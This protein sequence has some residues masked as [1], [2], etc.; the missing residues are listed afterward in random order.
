[1]SN[2]EKAPQ[3]YRD[4][5]EQQ[6]LQLEEK[7]KKLSPA[8]AAQFQRESREPRATVPP[9]GKA[10][11]FRPVAA[12]PAQRRK[13]VKSRNFKGEAVL[14]QI[15][16]VAAA[17]SEAE[18][19]IYGVIGDDWLDEG[20][21]A[22]GFNNALKDIG[23]VKNIKLRINSG[24]GDVF[25]AT[26]IYNMLVKHPANVVIE[27]EGVAASA[28]TIIAMAG[29]EIRIAANAHWM[30]H[31]ASGGVWGNADEMR[32]YI[33]LLDNADEMIRLTYSARTGIEDGELV[34]MMSTNNWMTAA[35]AL[36]LGFVDSVDEAKK[37]EAV[38]EPDAEDKEPTPKAI[39][40]ERLA[41]IAD[42][43]QNLSLT[44]EPMRVAASANSVKLPT[45]VD[46]P[47]ET[48]EGNEENEM[49]KELRA[50]LVAAGMGSKLSDKEAWAWLDAN[51]EKVYGASKPAP[52]PAPVDKTPVDKT[53]VPVAI[54]TTTVTTSQP[55]AAVTV[56][57]I[58]AVI[59]AREQRA[60]AKRKEW[61][62][63]VDAHVSLVFDDNVPAGLTET[64]YGLQADG[65]GPVRE[66]L[67]KAKKA[68]ADEDGSTLGTGVNL[69][70][71]QP[72]D[73]HLQAIRAGLLVRS[74]QNFVS[75]SPR[76]VKDEAGRWNHV[77]RSPQEVME[78]HLP[79]KD[80]PKD[81]QAFAS[82]PLVKLAEETLLADGHSH[83]SI[84]R[85]NG[86]S[87]AMAA[88]GYAR[89][90]GLKNIAVHTT[91]SFPEITRDA[92]NK[93]LQVG[94]EEAPQTW[95]GPMRQGTS[96]SD[97]KD[98]HRVKLGAAANL[99]VWPDN[100]TPEVAKLSEEKEKYA[101]EAHAETLQFSWRLI[102]NDDLDALSR[103]P[104]LLGDAA[105]RTVNAVAWAEVTGNPLL[106]DGVALFA[107]AAGARKRDNLI[108]GSATPTN[109]TIGAQKKLM[110]LMR[111]LNTP[112]GNESEDI[113]NLTPTYI[114][115]PAALEEVILKQVFSGADPAS[116]GNSA[117]FNTAR[118]LQ[119]IVEPLLD[120]NSATAWYLFASPNR[121]DT[122]EVTFLQGQETPASH[123]WMDDA[124]M[125][126]N[127]TI[128]QTFAAKA[129]DHRG[130]QRHDGA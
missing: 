60:A 43:L 92:V 104:Q 53:P 21:T 73:R 50:K 26:A 114:V 39:T 109:I 118:T 90:A 34:E 83:D 44:L 85:L 63:E 119:P 103:R 51:H 108:T 45:G 67:K 81:W 120:A 22:N 40:S 128:M 48:P 84:R 116:G 10:T 19:L 58:D 101:V 8:E 91:G 27:V 38:T 111:G 69:S 3:S 7:Y 97:F 105:S 95:R 15:K 113:L 61:R 6:I 25:D 102:V 68:V 30:I 35:K 107:V 100:S 5:T 80:R 121:V 33:N 9:M 20:V 123:E 4:L 75:P 41:A 65:I 31:S 47:D 88:M 129:I 76:L 46:P 24:G 36:E 78:D 98:I 42:D 94:Y 32:Q 55:A 56:E 112:E 54:G 93:S 89:Q 1:M 110:R 57:T 77:A 79:E 23:K 13:R 66:A 14:S 16:V 71:N 122:I 127:F 117:V 87:V 72:R 28:A 52:A 12:S 37:V 125:C 86:T 49:N 82:M 62:D 59:E 99:P 18:I 11:A 126:Q 29:D 124:T 115:G 64:C 2:P 106:A 74:M 17:N 70:P 130:A 96:V